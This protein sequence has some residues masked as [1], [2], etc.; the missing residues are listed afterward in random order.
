MTLAALFVLAVYLSNACTE[1]TKKTSRVDHLPYYQDAKFTPYWLENNA[2]A[3]DTFHSIRPFRL[4]NQDSQIITEETVK[5]HIYVVDFFF[6][7]CPGICPK[8]TNNMLLLQDEFIDDEDV[9]LLS[10][11]VTPDIDSVH[12]LL[13]Y[14]QDFGIRSD[15]WHLLTGDQHEIYELGR[16]YYFVEEDLG[17]DKDIDEFLHTENFVL[18]DKNR[19]I[20]GIY[21]GLSKPS[22]EQLK[23]DIRTLQKE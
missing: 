17:I 6:T 8:M 5:D 11:S 3:L 13:Q 23:V 12:I 19:H 18:M 4:I 10:H 2:I 9:L 14:A 20:R 21:N 7:T 16:R 1:P 15:R 22:L